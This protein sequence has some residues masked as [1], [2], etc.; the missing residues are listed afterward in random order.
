[1]AEKQA[2]LSGKDGTCNNCSE[3]IL[4]IS[5]PFKRMLSVIDSTVFAALCRRSLA[6][7]VS[8]K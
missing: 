8:A 5:E 6:L 7:E 2:L 3:V 1:M 4:L